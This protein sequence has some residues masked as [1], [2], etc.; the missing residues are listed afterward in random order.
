MNVSGRDANVCRQDELRPIKVSAKA[1]CV[2]TWLEPELA[3]S[4]MKDPESECLL[5]LKS[6][7]KSINDFAATTV[8]NDGNTVQVW[9]CLSSHKLHKAFSLVPRKPIFV[10]VFGQRA[11][12]QWTD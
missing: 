2:N 8:G 12:A 4:E 1:D 5:F 10:L 11:A 9:A 6:S 7:G 3:A